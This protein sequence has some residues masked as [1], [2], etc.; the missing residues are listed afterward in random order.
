MHKRSLER[1]RLQVVCAAWL[2]RPV[3]L[4]LAFLQ[5]SRNLPLLLLCRF[6]LMIRD[7]VQGAGLASRSVFHKKRMLKSVLADHCLCIFSRFD[8]ARNLNRNVAETNIICLLKWNGIYSLAESW[9]TNTWKVE[10]LKAVH[11]FALFCTACKSSSTLKH[12]RS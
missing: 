5:S 2:W 6:L 4:S 9:D 12:T 3:L 11:I 8:T 10:V 1:C 7:T